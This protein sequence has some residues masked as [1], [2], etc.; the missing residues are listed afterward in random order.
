M[1]TLL[2]REMRMSRRHIYVGT[3]YLTPVKEKDFHQFLVVDATDKLKW[4]EN[5]QECNHFGLYLLAFAKK[6]FVIKY[7]KNAAVGLLWMIEKGAQRGHALNFIITPELEVRYYE[8][9]TDREVFPV[10]RKLFV[11]I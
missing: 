2:S 8:P 9:Q 7:K 11:L 4:I 10:G 1:K 5:V 6:W 3:Q